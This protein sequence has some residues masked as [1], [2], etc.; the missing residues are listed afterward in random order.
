MGRPD[1]YKLIRIRGIGLDLTISVRP[2]FSLHVLTNGRV[3]KVRM[4]AT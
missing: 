4:L 2:A 1:A 3:E